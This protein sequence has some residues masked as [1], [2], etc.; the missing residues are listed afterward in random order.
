V[1]ADKTPF[2]QF[3]AFETLTLVPIDLDAIEPS[4]MEPR[5]IRLLNAYHRRVCEALT[6]FMDEEERAWLT[7]ATRELEV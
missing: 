3:Y 2:G 1:E 5:D 4:V 6:P 7:H